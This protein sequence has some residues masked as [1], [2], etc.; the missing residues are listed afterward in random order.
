[1]VNISVLDC[2]LRDGGYV[3]NWNFGKND[4]Q[5]IIGELHK[6]KIEFIECGFLE[7]GCC[8]KNKSKFESIEIIN[9]YLLSCVDKNKIVAMIAYGK[10]SINKIPT[11][12]DE[13]ITALR[14]IYK[15]HQ[16]KDA[17]K[18]AKEI[19]ARGYKL[20]I[21]PTFINF[22]S[23]NEFKKTIEEINLI[24]PYAFTIVDSMGALN[25]EKLLE[26]INIANTHLDKDISL[27]VHLHNNFQL[28]FANIQKILRLNFE[29]KIIIDGSI[30]GMGRGAGNLPIEILTDYLNINYEKKYEKKYILNIADKYILKIF[31]NTPWGYSIPYYLSAVN[32]C[33][34]NYATFL[35]NKKV[36]INIMDKIF[37][38]ISEEYKS[39]YNQGLI[40]ELYN[41][42][43]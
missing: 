33:H 4:I 7:D 1:M 16:I 43:C 30:L 38:N 37:K 19:I 24:K 36:E 34:P 39:E 21:N 32:N 27:C 26:Y 5:S 9:Q 12:N 42:Y 31:K 23:L 22:Y 8:D 40:N 18:Y 20:F 29:R 3:N 2:T 15:K 35:L 25:E 28:C 17:L 14:L 10:F 6:S 13:L 11:R 41:K